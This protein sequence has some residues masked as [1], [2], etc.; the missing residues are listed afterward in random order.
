M[1]WDR[2]IRTRPMTPDEILDGLR[3]VYC[4]TTL[5]PW[6]EAVKAVGFDT[7]LKDLSSEAGDE[8]EADSQPDRF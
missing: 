4:R 5:D 2:P 7:D 6:P 8:T 1:S 3:D